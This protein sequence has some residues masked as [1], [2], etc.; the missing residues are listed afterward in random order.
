MDYFTDDLRFSISSPVR[1]PSTYTFDMKTKQLGVLAE[2]K[3]ANLEYDLDDLECKRVMVTGEG[4]VQIP[5]TLFY[6][7]DVV[8]T[9]LDFSMTR[10]LMDRSRKRHCQHLCQCTALTGTMLSWNGTQ[11]IYLSCWRYF[12]W[13]VLPASS[14]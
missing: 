5:M 4:G 10:N 11:I 3:V 13:F 2:T 9:P 6:R 7:R 1:P 8:R 12:R 14:D